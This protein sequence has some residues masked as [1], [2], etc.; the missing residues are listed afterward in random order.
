VMYG[1]LSEIKGVGRKITISIGFSLVTLCLIFS[2]ISTEHMICFY[3]MFYSFTNVGN[4]LFTYASEVYPTKLRDIGIGWLSCV[5]YFGSAIS[6]YALILPLKI[7]WKAPLILMCF[8]S[9]LG[10][11][12]ICFSPFETL[13]RPLDLIQTEFKDEEK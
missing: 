6:Q 10:A 3:T 5:T 4:T 7:S 9:F 8:I 1:I 12:L 11:V 13:G 2:V